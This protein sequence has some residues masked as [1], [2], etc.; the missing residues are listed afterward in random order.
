MKMNSDNNMKQS[1]GALWGRHSS[2]RGP[3]CMAYPSYT[4]DYS[5]NKAGS[6]HRICTEKKVTIINPI[7]KG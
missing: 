1:K 3:L 2:F 5:A 6:M 7:A 4:A